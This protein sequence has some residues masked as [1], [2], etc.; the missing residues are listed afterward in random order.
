[1]DSRGFQSVAQAEQEQDVVDV[2]RVTRGS[3]AWHVLF[4][5]ILQYVG[6]YSDCHTFGW[7]EPKECDFLPGACSPDRCFISNKPLGGG[8]RSTLFTRSH[9]PPHPHP[10]WEGRFGPSGGCS[11]AL[12]FA[13]LSKQKEKRHSSVHINP[14]GDLQLKLFTITAIICLYS[15]SWDFSSHWCWIRGLISQGAKRFYYS[16]TDMSSVQDSGLQGGNMQG[17]PPGKQ[18]Y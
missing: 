12:L 1:V 4:I 18:T 14:A 16:Y 7:R 13:L 2:L 10:T 11:D 8:Y 5:Y 3:G 6:C 9:P 17:R 15:P